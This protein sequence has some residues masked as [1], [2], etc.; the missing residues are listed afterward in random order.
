MNFEYLGVCEFREALA[1]QEALRVQPGTVLGFEPMEPVVT[2][3]RR[4]VLAD[5]TRAFPS[6][7]VD[8]G[9]QA[10]LHNPG[11]LVIF[12]VCQVESVREWVDRLWRVSQ[13]ALSDFGCAAEWDPLRPGLYTSRGKI[14]SIGVRVKSGVSTHGIAINIRNRLEDFAVIRACGISGAAMDRLGEEFEPKEVF[15]RWI[16]RFSRVDN[17]PRFDKDSVHARS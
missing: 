10:T 15:L 14:A 1:R 9:G 13:G 17:E 6:F 7:E 16:Q 4:T 5:R 12:P 8:R 2:Y 3:G 11:Q